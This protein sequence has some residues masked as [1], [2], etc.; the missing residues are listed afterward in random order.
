MRKIYFFERAFE[1]PKNSSCGK[2]PE[3]KQSII[4]NL[5]YLIDYLV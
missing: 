5:D 4:D 3:E 1:K 2:F